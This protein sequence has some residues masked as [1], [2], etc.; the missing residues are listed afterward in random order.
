MWYVDLSISNSNLGWSVPVSGALHTTD[1]ALVLENLIIPSTC[2]KTLQLTWSCWE[3]GHRA[4]DEMISG[5]DE[6]IWTHSKACLYLSA[7]YERDNWTEKDWPSGDIK[8]IGYVFLYRDNVL[9]SHLCWFSYFQKNMAVLNRCLATRQISTWN[10]EFKWK[11][12]KA[13]ICRKLSASKHGK[14]FTM[15]GSKET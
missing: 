10:E 12:W 9:R 5:V 3:K 8:E 1:D 15:W 13:K 14:Q 7:S 2:A 4:I 11:N 6:M